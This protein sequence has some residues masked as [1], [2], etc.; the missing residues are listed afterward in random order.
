[1]LNF[2]LN[3]AGKTLPQV[4]RKR[5][6][7]AKDELRDLFGR[8]ESA[9]GPAK[10]DEP[11]AAAPEPRTSLNL[12]QPRRPEAS[13]EPRKVPAAE[14]VGDLLQQPESGAKEKPV[15]RALR[16]P[17]EAS[18]S[19]TAADIEVLSPLEAI[20][21]RPETYLGPCDER[22]L[23]LLLR[24]LVAS[25][26]QQHLEGFADLVAVHSLSEAMRVLEQEP[27]AVDLVISTLTFSDHRMLE[28]L[29]EVR[30]N[31]RTG[32][33]PFLVCRVIVGRLSEELV[34]RMGVLARQFDAEFLNFGRLPDGE[35]VASQGTPQGR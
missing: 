8:P 17:A 9:T 21:R 30:G 23:D 26:L 2:Y 29:L 10:E 14:P 15:A 1:M 6:E 27:P 16:K 11:Q 7:S 35:A 24:M 22:G 13:R 19:Y 28:F 3:R 33:I 34:E 31:P 4:Q 32:A 18:D 25:V 12:V 20:R 5:L